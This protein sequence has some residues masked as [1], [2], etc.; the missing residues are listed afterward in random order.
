MQKARYNVNLDNQH[1]KSLAI[2]A[3]LMNYLEE[4]LDFIKRVIIYHE[5][6]A[7]W[8]L[9][10]KRICLSDKPQ[11]IVFSNIKIKDSIFNP[12][13]E[14]HRQVFK[15][16]ISCELEAQN[17][18]KRHII[19]ICDDGLIRNAASFTT[20][21]FLIDSYVKKLNEFLDKLLKRLK[22]LIPFVPP[23]HELEVTYQTGLNFSHD[24][25]TTIPT[26]PT[27]NDLRRDIDENVYRDDDSSADESSENGSNHDTN[28]DNGSEN[29]GDDSGGNDGDGRVLTHDISPSTIGDLENKSPNV[30]ADDFN[31]DEN[32]ESIDRPESAFSTTDLHDT[33]NL[34]KDDL[35]SAS[36]MGSPLTKASSNLIQER[37]EEMGMRD[38][39]EAENYKMSFITTH[40]TEMKNEKLISQIIERMKS[41]KRLTSMNLTDNSYIDDVLGLTLQEDSAWFEEFYI[42]K[43][44][45]FYNTQKIK[46][47]IFD[48]TIGDVAINF[49]SDKCLKNFLRSVRE[50]AK[51][52]SEDRQHLK[53][54]KYFENRFT[55][56]IKDMLQ[57]MV[58]NIYIKEAM[59]H[60]LLQWVGKL[61]LKVLKELYE[62]YKQCQKTNENEQKRLETDN[63]DAMSQKDQSTKN[64]QLNFNNTTNDCVTSFNHPSCHKIELHFNPLTDAGSS[65]C[66]RCTPSVV[67]INTD[68]RFNPDPLN[69]KMS[70]RLE[71]P[72]L[73]TSQDPEKINGSSTKTDRIIVKQDISNKTINYTSSIKSPL[74]DEDDGV[75]DNDIYEELRNDMGKTSTFYPFIHDYESSPRDEPTSN[76]RPQDIGPPQ[77]DTAPIVKTKKSKKRKKAKKDKSTNLPST[78]ATTTKKLRFDPEVVSIVND[79]TEP[80]AE[81]T[82]DQQVVENTLNID[83][84]INSNQNAK[85]QITYQIILH[86]RENP[87]GLNLVRSFGKI[88]IKPK[89]SMNGIY[90]Q[91]EIGEF[92]EKISIVPNDS[93]DKSSIDLDGQIKFPVGFEK[94]IMK[95]RA[96]PSYIKIMGRTSYTISDIINVPFS[97]QEISL[98]LFIKPVNFDFMKFLIKDMWGVSIKMSFDDYKKLINNFKIDAIEEFV[99][100]TNLLTKE[101]YDY[102]NSQIPHLTHALLNLPFPF[103][104]FELVFFI[105]YSHIVY[106][107]PIPHILRVLINYCKIVNKHGESG[108]FFEWQV[109]SATDEYH[110]K[111]F[112]LCALMN[113]SQLKFLV[114]IFSNYGALTV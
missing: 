87:T 11:K 34:P 67:E 102:N 65:T 36:E 12:A 24:V 94:N 17:Y 43:Y 5:E 22:P 46:F 58:E 88:F 98:S 86:K 29:H 112:I 14:A 61:K 75:S 109:D 47:D 25:A 114:D 4:V 26:M 30:E 92:I 51:E 40:F 44:K 77:S 56:I 19:P 7:S 35:T 45:K 23:F 108:N 59:W 89:P 104:D 50:K 91:N 38:E 66:Q 9:R 79:N 18:L 62:T 3:T 32:L 53:T 21:V 10:V 84:I 78:D 82:I 97:I 20:I 52:N 69:L 13:A 16:D 85:Q 15:N 99:N 96:N 33:T 110:I 106:K 2:I 100:K 68:S 55:A 8:Y 81:M 71:N 90:V 39:I 42:E 113:K 27:F 41:H 49:V 63:K 74:G 83:T 37:L 57:C 111:R 95:F 48:E 31:R 60:L 76:T 70:Q 54:V 101:M 64:N 80:L 28:N 103:Y 6:T 1:K 72:P 107:Y 105:E 93:V 73:D